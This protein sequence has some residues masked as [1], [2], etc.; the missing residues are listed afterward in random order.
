M[1]A[2]AIE[3]ALADCEAKIQEAIRVKETVVGEAR[4]QGRDITEAERGLLEQQTDQIKRYTAQAS[5]YR[6]HVALAA[7]SRARSEE[8]SQALTLVR[9]PDL[10]GFSYRSAG[11]YV[12]DNVRAIRGDR[13]AGDRIEHY[14]RVAAHQTTT[15]AAGVVPQ[16]VV[17]GVINFIDSARPLVTALG[18]R[19][20][21]GGPNFFRPRVTTHTVVGKQSAEKAEFASQAMVLD[22]LTATVDTY[23][24]YVNVSRQIIDWSSPSI[25]DIVVGDLAAQYAIQTE[26]AA[27]A[28]FSA[29]ATA[30]TVIPTGATSADAIASAVW[31]AVGAIYTAIPIGGQIVGIASPAMLSVI[32]PAFAPVNPAN[33]Q[34]TGFT[35]ANF[36]SG[37]MGSIGGV[38]IYVSPRLTGSQLLVMHPSA[39]EVYDQQIGMLSVVEPSVGGVQVAYMG[40]F[41]AL[42]VAAGGI[43][44]ITKTP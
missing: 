34:S 33:S 13:E 28:Q 5:P 37:L 6:E 18:V 31:A 26:T 12:L 1:G 27:A 24:G 35:A 25:M 19:Q 10:A 3:D 7:Q 23:G 40:Y 29:A 2:T 38:P 42:T 36:G 21:E 20:L 11:H 41:S 32:G 16:E 15:N 22:K 17:G 43:I 4:A 8:L 9:R 44:K 14:N 30:G 39:A